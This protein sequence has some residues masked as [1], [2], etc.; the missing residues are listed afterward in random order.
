MY[1]M[2]PPNKFAAQANHQRYGIVLSC[3][4]PR[5]QPRTVPCRIGIPKL[6]HA[7]FNRSRE[8]SVNEKWR[9]E[10]YKLG[11]RNAKILFGNMLTF[12]HSRWHEEALEPEHARA[13]HCPQFT[14]IAGHDPA[15]EADVHPAFLAR[16]SALGFER[17][18]CGGCR[19]AVERHVDQRRDAASG[20]RACRRLKT[21]PIGAP[22]F[23]DMDMRVHQAGHDDR[24]SRV[25]HIRSARQIV[26]AAHR[27]VRSIA[28]VHGCR[29][30]TFRLHPA[31][32]A[33]RV[34]C[35]HRP[36]CERNSSSRF[37]ATRRRYRAVERIS[38]IGEISRESVS[39]AAAMISGASFA[40]R[41]TSSVF[42]ARSTMGAMLPSAMR[43]S[44]IVSASICAAP[45]MH[46]LEI[47]CALRVPTFL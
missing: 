34:Y 28:N 39:F 30:S 12:R 4:R 2:R 7:F 10:F 8:F 43:T 11:H 35:L 20:G 17:R 5:K 37:C 15:P 29:L 33:N 32:A 3:W 45:A 6:L 16:R 36:S 18:S 14:G 25:I 21:F 46:T 40:P 26:I 23:I 38:S 22:R 9:D 24:S 27:C 13:M 31:L 47:A 1:D 44:R 41:S 19:D 42:T